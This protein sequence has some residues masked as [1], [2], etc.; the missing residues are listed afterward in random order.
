MRISSGTSAAYIAA[1]GFIF[2]MWVWSADTPATAINCDPASKL[3]DLI[4][5]SA[6]RPYVSRMLVPVLTRTVVGLVPEGM[7]ATWSNA[8]LSS[9]AFRKQAN[10]LGWE[11]EFLPEYLV[12]FGLAF[13]ALAAYVF[14]FRHL[15]GSMYET[16]RMTLEV[17]P[18][19]SLLFLPPFFLVGPHYIYDFPALMFFT[20]GMYLIVKRRWMLFYPAFVIGMLNKETMVLLAIAIPVVL[21]GVMDRRALYLHAAGVAAIGIAIR[22]ALF[23]AFSSNPGADVWLHLHWN[24]DALLRPYDWSSLVAVAGLAGMAVYDWKRK[25]ETLRRLAVLIVPF[26]ILVLLFGM[27]HELRDV[28]EIAP[29]CYLLVAHTVV[30]RMFGVTYTAIAA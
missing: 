17:L 16:D 6:S 14:V 5:G 29:I 24:V 12:A 18:L 1:S 13:L 7:K 15:V 28:L 21:N 3:S 27:V 25:P 30:F 9:P 20:L 19:G 26:V 10:R 4:S 2:L 8:L 22:V 11:T 23:A